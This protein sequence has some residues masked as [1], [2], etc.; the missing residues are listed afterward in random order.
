MSHL[1]R[2]R[3]SLATKL[4]LL[5]VL[6]VVLP[7]GTFGWIA[8]GTTRAALER[9]VGRQLAEVAQDAAERVDIE[10]ARLQATLNGW[11]REEGLR[12]VSEPSATER[13]AGLLHSLVSS[14][15]SLGSLLCS[16]SAGRVVAGG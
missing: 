9:A 16:D 11:A 8:L 12:E 5:S 14:D 7:G 15:A 4:L 1:L 2:V 10:I 13:I 6:L 3:T